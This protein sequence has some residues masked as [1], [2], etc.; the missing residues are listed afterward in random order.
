M[1]YRD[2]LSRLELIPRSRFAAFWTGSVGDQASI[3]SH[4]IHIECLFAIARR[5]DHF[6]E[7]M[8]PVGLVIVML[9][10]ETWPISQKAFPAIT[11]LSVWMASAS[12]SIRSVFG[13]ALLR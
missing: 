5:F 3:A 6:G 10:R 9:L 11:G 1:R 12:R 4:S 13:K 7:N 2:R 8:P